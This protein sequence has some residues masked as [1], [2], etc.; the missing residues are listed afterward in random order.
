MLRRSHELAS[1]SKPHTDLVIA[2]LYD[3]HGNEG[4]EIIARPIDRMRMRGLMPTL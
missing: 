1:A 3:V 4:T 2:W